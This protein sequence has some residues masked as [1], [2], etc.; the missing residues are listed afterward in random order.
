MAVGSGNG[1]MVCGLALM[2]ACGGNTTDSEPAQDVVSTADTSMAPDIAA[3]ADTSTGED[4][5][6]PADTAVADTNPVPDVSPD[7]IDTVDPVDVAPAPDTAA[8]PTKTLQSGVVELS[9]TQDIEGVPTERIVLLHAPKNVAPG[10]EYPVVFFFHGAGGQAQQ[11]KGKAMP[12]VDQGLYV[13]VY[14]S[15]HE[16]QWNTGYQKTK[17]D[18][19]AFA[20][21]IV[22]ALQEYKQLDFARMFVVGSSNGAALAHELAIHTDH[23]VGITAIVTA[24]TVDS[25]PND[26]T[27]TVGVLQI[28]GMKDNLCKYE[29]GTAPMGMTFLHAE[30]SAAVWATHNGCNAQPDTTTTAEGNKRIEYTGCTDGTRVLH[31]GITEAAHGMPNNTEGG[32]FPLFWSFFESLP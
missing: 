14:P 27:P 15:G 17:A 24:L 1:W 8:P 32:I 2:I 25:Q 11:W 5:A 3:P 19:V 16:K 22:D 31:Y 18:D 9:I 23:F 13:G 7:P 10:A 26:T 12:Y 30:E 21:M 4:T 29:G 20:G 28:L 6:A